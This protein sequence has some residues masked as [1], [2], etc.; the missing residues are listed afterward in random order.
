MEKQQP[1]IN[2]EMILMHLN[3]PNDIRALPLACHENFRQLS[4]NNPYWLH[5]VFDV[6]VLLL[7]L[8]FLRITV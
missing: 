6:L 1:F 2:A 8:L 4:S 7:L 3:D 5:Y